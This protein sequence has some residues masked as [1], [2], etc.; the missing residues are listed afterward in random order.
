LVEIVSKLV[1]SQHHSGVWQGYGLTFDSSFPSG[2]MLRAVLVAGALTAVWP[3]LR[4]PLRWWCGVVAI[5][6]LITAFHRP[7]DIVGGLL[8]GI[9]LRV[10]AEDVS[11]GR[12]PRRRNRRTSFSSSS[13]AQS[14]TGPSALDP[15]GT[16]GSR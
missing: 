3:S 4:T 13:S 7:T 14:Q 1:V 16:F 11:A 10:W 5:C 2:H 6:L 8:A 12:R 9:A 15:Q